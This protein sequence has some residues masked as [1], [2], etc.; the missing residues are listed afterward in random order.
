M[1]SSIGCLDRTEFKKTQQTQRDL[2]QHSSSPHKICP[3]FFN[4]FF[5]KNRDYSAAISTV[6]IWTWM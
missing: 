1:E 5:I 4:Q 6:I 3:H 2:D